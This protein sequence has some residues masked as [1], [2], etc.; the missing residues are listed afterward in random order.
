MFLCGCTNL[1]HAAAVYG[2]I[3]TILFAH[4]INLIS[5]KCD[6]ICTG[7]RRHHYSL[8]VYIE[9]TYSINMKSI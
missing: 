9:S 5:V 2:R 3:S 7:R 4:Y 1:Q 6:K 8:R